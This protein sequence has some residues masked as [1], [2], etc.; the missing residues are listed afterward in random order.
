MLL[1]LEEEAYNW[2]R[3]VLTISKFN[4][5]EKKDAQ[6]QRAFRESRRIFFCFLIF[7]AN[8]NKALS[9]HHLLSNFHFKNKKLF[10]VSKCCSC[11]KDNF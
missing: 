10:G 9:F 1:L 7:F 8:E 4:L 5:I 11:K 2:S 3:D 6:K